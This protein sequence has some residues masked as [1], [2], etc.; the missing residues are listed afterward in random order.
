MWN[1]VVTA[2]K[3]SNV[4]LCVTGNFTSPSEQNLI[5]AKCNRL[6]IYKLTADGLQPVMD[7]PIY[8]RIA[9]LEL[10]RINGAEKDLLFLTTERWKFCVL[11]YD[12]S[13]GELLT[14]AM[15]DVSDRIGKAVDS[16][17][18][19][20]IDPERRL[21]GLHLYDGFFKVIPIDP[22]GSLKE[23]F[24]IRLEE[25]QVIDLQFLYG[26]AVPTILLLYQDPKEMRHLKT[27][28]ISIKEKDFQPGPWQQT[29]V[30]MGATLIIPVP[31][32]LGGAVLVGEQ[33][34]TYLNGDK[35]ETKTIPM[36][37]TVI[38]AWG[39]ID[40]NGSR[41]LLGD[42][43]GRL[44]VLVLEHDGSKVLGLK[45]DLLGETSAAHCIAYLDSGV[46]FVGSSSADSQLIRLHPDKDEGGSNIEVLETFANLGPIQDFC[47]VDLERQGQGQVITCSGT[48]KD[49]SLRVVRNGIG[50]H[51]QAS[52]E[53]PG[54]KGLWSLRESYDARFDRYLVQSF[55][56]E[57]RVLA[58]ADEEMVET[59]IDGFDG[60]V[61]S[62]YCGNCVGDALVQVTERGVRLVSASMKT[63]VAQWA[64]PG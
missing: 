11:E 34:L 51:E 55:I 62:L 1:Y 41:Y 37:P 25:L 32:P 31:M 44:Y 10:Y 13:S 2:H 14:R 9:N 7:T 61:H 4:N 47:V 26:C 19:A 24:N 38:R 30:E 52:V 60:A 64:P 49:G 27:Y 46:V 5:V 63:L 35:G 50:I 3:P 18:I 28:E 33:T 17:Q 8:G 39:K 20:H 59:D 45:L 42:H 22:K 53:L 56:G 48:L 21:I 6:V 12:S 15:G 54:I 29:G 23:A 43:F 16:G 36:S 58:I 57:T 40:D